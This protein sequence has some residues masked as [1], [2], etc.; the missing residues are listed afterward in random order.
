MY[1]KIIKKFSSQISFGKPA[2]IVAAKRTPVTTFMGKFSK[3]KGAELG[4]IAIKSAL[5]SINL[6]GSDVNEVIMGT[7]CQAGQGQN[8]TR[9]A[10][11]GGGKLIIL[12]HS[13]LFLHFFFLGIG[14]NVPCTT[15]NKVCSSG[16]KSV[17]Y[18]AMSVGLGINQTV[19]TGGF[20]SM[21]NAPFL[22]VNVK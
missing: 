18:G 17:V 13:H 11:L 6:L 8:P 7:V 10:S 3:F 15:I 9:Q 21:T 4:A 2:Y 12:S 19:V 22:M 14:I 16:L 20:E 1:L 5:H